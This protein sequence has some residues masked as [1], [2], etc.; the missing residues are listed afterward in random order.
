MK[1]IP[2]FHDLEITQVQHS[3][4]TVRSYSRLYSYPYTEM[5]QVCVKCGKSKK[6]KI[7]GYWTF[8]NLSQKN[9]LA[10]R[11]TRLNKQE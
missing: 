10:Y 5:Y 2:F 1:C 8:E 4:Y 9:A 11:K 3:H 7:E 6:T